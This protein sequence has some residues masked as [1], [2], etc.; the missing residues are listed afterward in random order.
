MNTLSPRLT[1]SRKSDLKRA[2]VR[3]GL[4]NFPHIIREYVAGYA[5]EKRSPIWRYYPLYQPELIEDYHEL[6]NRGLA[7]WSILN[8]TGQDRESYTDD[9]DREAYTAA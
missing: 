1:Y 9:Q 5:G 8:C 6:R 3:Q 7:V 4:Q 2:Q